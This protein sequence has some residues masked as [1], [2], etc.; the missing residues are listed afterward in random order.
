MPNFLGL[1]FP[2]LFETVLWNTW[3]YCVLINYL[4][5]FSSFYNYFWFISFMHRSYLPRGQV[6]THSEN[7]AE[8]FGF[9]SGSKYRALSNRNSIK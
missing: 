8:T 1:T 9:Y 2:L 6:H 5:W 7:M 4:L 3:K